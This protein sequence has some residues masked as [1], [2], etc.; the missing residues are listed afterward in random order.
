MS[1]AQGKVAVVTGAGSGIGRATAERLLG[2]GMRVSAWDLHADALA[3]L[4][5]YEESSY[6]RCRVDVRSEDAARDAAAATQARWGHIDLLVNAAG[7]FLV[8]PLTEVTAAAIADLFAVNVIG[9]TLVTQACL[10]ALMAARGA[11]V[12]VASTVAVKPTAS[13][14]HYA[15][16][17]A[18]VAQLT[19]CWALELAP[20]GIRVN[21]VAPG[22]TRTGIYAR[23][24]MSEAQINR[25]LEDRAARIPLG[26]TGTP[27]EI[28]RWIVRLGLEDEW[29]TGQVLAVDGGMSVT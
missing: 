16:S 22:P 18:A 8:G 29:V 12:N 14:S 3:W 26:R 13:N 7:L 25:L 23:A 19:R 27:E 10:P 6:L 17:K 24:G 1:I 4:D 15:A 21:A 11:V 9:T 20:H 2:L 28:A 5:A